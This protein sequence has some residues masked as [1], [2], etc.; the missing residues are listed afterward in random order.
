MESDVD[1]PGAGEPVDGE[2]DRDAVSDVEDES[3]AEGPEL[4][5]EDR[6]EDDEEL[7]QR[8]VALKARPVP[9]P[10]PHEDPTAPNILP[11]P[12]PITHSGGW[13]RW[14]LRLFVVSLLI[15]GAG[16]VGYAALTIA[17]D[18]AATGGR[19]PV[20]G[21]LMPDDGH[22]RDIADQLL[23]RKRPEKLRGITVVG[24]D[25][26]VTVI[27]YQRG[28]PS[29]L[30]SYLN[31]NAL[32]VIARA[33]GVRSDEPITVDELRLEVLER[34][35][36]QRWRLRGTQDGRPWRAVVNPNG[37]NLRLIPVKVS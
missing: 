10:P 21:V 20:Y 5:G 32:Q 11:P 1:I 22:F 28:A 13:R 14:I 4:E 12:P 29:F 34:T 35:G 31:P 33:I 27:R 8:P 16:T 2:Q 7:E 23:A 36:R 25:G 18:E 26:K 15:A 19:K 24:E 37:T 6:D 3:R 17:D 30:S 9:A